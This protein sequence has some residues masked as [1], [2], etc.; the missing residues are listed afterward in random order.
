[1]WK[2][3]LL[4]ADDEQTNGGGVHHVKVPEAVLRAPEVKEVIHRK[5]EEIVQERTA[6]KVNP[7]AYTASMYQAAA[8]SAVPPVTSTTNK[9]EEVNDELNSA[10]TEKPV[11]EKQREEGDVIAGGLTTI[12]EQIGMLTQTLGVLE[13]RL[14]QN[15]DRTEEMH[16]KLD[17]LIERLGKA[18]I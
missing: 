1:M 10:Y 7:N 9:K 8:T 16:Q 3:N 4:F 2:S 17:Y 14:S 12:V 11:Q 15:E 18:T 6:A 5:P 13:S